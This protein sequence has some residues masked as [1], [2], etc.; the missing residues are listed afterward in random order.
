MTRTAIRDLFGRHKSTDRLGAA[1]GLLAKKSRARW[2][3]KETGG[4]PSEAWFA[5]T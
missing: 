2:E 1:L 5:V 4:R 3:T